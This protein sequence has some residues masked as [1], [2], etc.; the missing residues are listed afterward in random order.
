MTG[1][2]LK[3]S[4]VHADLLRQD[5]RH[6]PKLKGPSI[7]NARFRRRIVAAIAVVILPSSLMIGVASASSS[8]SSSAAQVSIGFVTVKQGAA[9][10]LHPNMST[11]GFR[12]T[13]PK[14]EGITPDSASG[15]NQAVCISLVGTG[16]TVTSWSTSAYF[17][18]QTPAFAI[19]YKNGTVIATSVIVEANPGEWLVDQMIGTHSFPNGTQLCNGWGGTLGHP[20][21]T[22]EG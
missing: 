15:C 8:H 11:P 16:L 1:S 22:I 14:V 7:F 21:E 3:F 9:L 12:V 13:T 6:H 19:Y 18:I 17:A 10:G 5:N 2:G 20:C 4:Y